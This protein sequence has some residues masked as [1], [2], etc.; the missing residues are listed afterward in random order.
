MKRCPRCDRT[1]PD[2]EKFCD[3]DGTAL[4]AGG[5]AFVEG[6]GARSDPGAAGSAGAG[7]LLG[8]TAPRRNVPRIQSMRMTI[9]AT[10]NTT[11]SSVASRLLRGRF[12]VSVDAV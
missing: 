5:P 6:A 3:A 8:W 11:R 2:S 10:E 12:D 7:C 9:V 4:V 1:Y